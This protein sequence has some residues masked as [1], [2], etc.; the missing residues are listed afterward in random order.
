MKK[1]MI[2][3]ATVAVGFAA[4]AAS[5]DWVYTVTGADK[6]DTTL[7]SGYS[8]YLFDKTTWDNVDFATKTL[9]AVLA[10]S[11]DNSD[12]ASKNVGM[13]T[14][15]KKTWGTHVDGGA[16]GTT[17]GIAVN[18]KDAGGDT[19]NGYIVVFNA[20]KSKYLA[21]AVSMT[22]RANGDSNSTATTA[23]LKPTSASFSGATWTAVAP[24]PTSGLLMLVGLGALALRRRRA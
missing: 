14:N 21:E 5:V 18:N 17:R 13:G 24:E 6:N 22:T 16:A 10:T 7:Y 23:E 19:F 3:L 20:D 12:F 9:A 1:L 2:V 11:L 4:H 8:A 15:A